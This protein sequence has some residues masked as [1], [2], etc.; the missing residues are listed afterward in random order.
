MHSGNN[1]KVSAKDLRVYPISAQD[2]NK[3]MRAHHY[4][5]KVVPNSSLHFGVF[6]NGVIEGAMQFGSCINKKGTINLVA[7]TGWNDFIELNRMAFSEKLPRN[8][9][10]RAIGYAMRLLRKHYPH[11]E[12]CISFADATQCGDGTIYRASGFVL[13]D[14][15]VNDVLRV[16]PD[17]GEQMHVIQAHHLKLSQEFKKWKPLAGFQ[18]RYIYFLNKQARDRLAVPEI[19]F[20]E[21]AA[22]G[23]A[24]Y[25]GNKR[26]LVEGAGIPSQQ[27]G[28]TPTRTLQS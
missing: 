6:L 22:K 24:M 4:S 18:M 27:G 12:W 20:T 8:S 7:G 9:E 21:I 2:A 1:H 13:T 16:N 19:P 17:T 11:L 15:R 23:A 10:S 26:A 28:S 14:I 5:G 25:K 3:F